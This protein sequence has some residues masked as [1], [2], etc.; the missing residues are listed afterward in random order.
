MGNEEGNVLIDKLLDTSD[1]T[2]R[3]VVQEGHAPPE[4][5]KSGVL[6]SLIDKDKPIV[7][8]TEK[9]EP[10]EAPEQADASVIDS[11]LSD[12]TKEDTQDSR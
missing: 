11:L 12:D 10:M 2:K 7:Q 3:A 1:E 9:S 5:K 8:S 4:D 6:D